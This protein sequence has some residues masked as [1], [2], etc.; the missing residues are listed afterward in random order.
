MNPSFF[1]MGGYVILGRYKHSSLNTCICF[2]SLPAFHQSNKEF[3]QVQTMRLKKTSLYNTCKKYVQSFGKMGEW[4]LTQPSWKSMS[5]SPYRGV[6][7]QKKVCIGLC[8]QFL[9]QSSN[10]SWNFQSGQGVEGLPWWLGDKESACNAGDWGSI[11]VSGPER[12]E[13]V[14]VQQLLIQSL[15][16]RQLE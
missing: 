15:L 6:R 5:S 12:T 8:P 1:K 7:K 4:K 9:T 10:K 16:L 14:C 2:C 13:S 11:P 3:K